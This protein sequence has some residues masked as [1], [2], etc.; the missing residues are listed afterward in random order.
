M[1]TNPPPLELIADET[2]LALLRA[3]HERDDAALG[4]LAGVAGIHLNTARKHL[5]ELEDA[6]M[7]ER[8]AAPA[9]GRGRPPLRYRMAEG[10]RLPGTDVLGLAELLGAIILRLV[11]DQER[12]EAVGRDW[13]RFLLRRPGAHEPSTDIPKAMGQLGFDVRLQRRTLR[14]AGC[15]CPLVMPGRPESLCGL[16][17]AVIDGTLEAGGSDLRVVDAKHDPAR[18]QCAVRLGRAS[19]SSAG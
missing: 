14:L 19:R 9:E 4:E 13:G 5:R 18:R 17:T 15:P 10:W 1:E 16:A 3:I 7:V 2:R 8:V 11:P 12:L 6:G